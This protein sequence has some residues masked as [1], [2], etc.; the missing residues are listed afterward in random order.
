MTAALTF[1]IALGLA[2][3]S[4]DFTPSGT[5]FLRQGGLAKEGAVIGGV[6]EG[7]TGETERYPDP[8]KCRVVIDSM[9]KVGLRIADSQQLVE[10]TKTGLYKRLGRDGAV[11]WEGAYEAAKKMGRLSHVQN[12]SREEKMAYL[13]AA[14]ENAEFRVRVRFKRKRSGTKITLSCRRA[15]MPPSKTLEKRVIRAKR[16]AEARAQLEK[17]IATL[18]IEMDPPKKPAPRAEDGGRKPWQR[19][20]KKPEAF[21]LPPRR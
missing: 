3:Q 11:V 20:K 1:L 21:V 2:S 5:K 8:K 4:G 18:C 6:R 17:E 15:G 13:K 19:K 7:A 16:F 9:G 10:T 12:A 14:M